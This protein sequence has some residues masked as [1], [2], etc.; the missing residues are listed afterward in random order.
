MAHC[1]GSGHGEWAPTHL[2]GAVIHETGP[3]ADTIL[4]A[5]NLE[6]ARRAHGIS[7]GT[8]CWGRAVD[9]A[10]RKERTFDA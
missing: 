7:R 10:S 9:G 3:V 6:A 2:P 8:T 5:G 1:G 4:L